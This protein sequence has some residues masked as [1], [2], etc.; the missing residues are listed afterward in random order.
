MGQWHLKA[1]D[2][3]PEDFD[4]Q[5]AEILGKLTNDLE[6]WRS[7]SRNFKVDLFCGWFMEGGDE[8][9]SISPSTMAALSERGIELGICIYGPPS[10]P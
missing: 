9:L 2:R 10:E 7:L 1:M 4:G 6:I 3:Q 5:V 8:G